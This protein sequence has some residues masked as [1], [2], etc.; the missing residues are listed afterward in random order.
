M[1]AWKY[2]YSELFWFAFFHIWTEYA[3][4]LAENTYL[5][6]SVQIWESVDQNNSEYGHFTQRITDELMEPFYH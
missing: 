1:T 5:S 6:Y 3:E 2:P 4:I